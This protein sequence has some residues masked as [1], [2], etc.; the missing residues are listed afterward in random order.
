M[1]D[2]YCDISAVGNEYQAYEDTPTTWGMPQDGNGK[3]GPG[4]SAA[5]AIATIDCTSAVGDGAQTLSILGVSVSNASSGSGA[6]LAASLVTSI[7]GTTTATT[8][9]YCQALLP[10][11]KLIFARQN[12]DNTAQVQ[13]M[14]RIAGA[15]WNGMAPTHAGFTTG[16]SITA[17]S[18]G[19]DGPFGYLCATTSVFGRT[20]P[21]WGCQS[22]I[23]VGGIT[24][25]GVT[26]V[27]HVRTRRS[28]ADLSLSFSS[29]NPV[30]WYMA[31][32]GGSRNFLV[33]DGTVWIGDAGQL[34]VQLYSSNGASSGVVLQFDGSR[35][36]VASRGSDK[37]M[38]YLCS[39]SY[40]QPTIGQIGSATN[41]L[42]EGVLFEVPSSAPAGQGWLLSFQTNSSHNVYL[43][44]CK[45]R[46]KGA[47][48]LWRF[49]VNNS[50]RFL[51]HDCDYE[52]FSLTG[53]ISGFISGTPGANE[54]A[55][56]V[57]C[58]FYDVNGVYQVVNPI[59]LNANEAPIRITFDSCIGV[60][61]VAMNL[62]ASNYSERMLTWDNYGPYRDF[63][64]ETGM[65]LSEWRYGNN[66][67]TLSAMLPNG[68]PWS[69][70]C[71]LRSTNLWQQTH[72][73]AR[74]F[75]TYRQGTAAREIK[76]EILAQRDL[77]D[78]EVGL[79][80][81]YADE[82]DIVRVET[83]FS[84]NLVSAILGAGNT[85]AASVAVWTL[86]GQTGFTAYKLTLTTAHK[87]KTLTDVNTFVIWRGP[88]PSDQTIYIDPEVSFT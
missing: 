48:A 67:P 71:L 80:A 56:F 75:K 14:L 2:F 28:G 19:V 1:T 68:T 15:D 52:F 26:D 35:V 57:G 49:S 24:E 85:L 43:N 82:N 72:R 86:N 29:S 61:D 39:G 47:G 63:R 70:K 44:R 55:E 11:N 18:G 38:R 20:A 5:V 22:N 30:Y 54:S 66:Q 36:A 51:A 41:F 23:K 83:T 87:V 79:M 10:L 74:I 8:A 27:I 84:E 17:F 77:K 7:N 32:T 58:R 4:H 42:A 21:S 62:A 65:Y 3:A 12:P 16:P 81:V 53:N 37:R 46:A 34:T 50:T 59:A 40:F 45:F 73:L 13:V 78:T 6:T 25:P 64:T 69:I 88:Q 76:V 33:D 31:P 60:S 9:T